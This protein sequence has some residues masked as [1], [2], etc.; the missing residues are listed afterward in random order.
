MQINLRPFLQNSLL[1]LIIGSLLILCITDASARRRYKKSTVRKQAIEMIVTNSEEV[2][3]LAGLEAQISDSLQ[4]EEVCGGDLL[5]GEK[6]EEVE[7]EDDV[8][9]DLEMVK[10]IWLEFMSEDDEQEY[11][12]CGIRK[13]EVMDII[14]DWLGTRYRYGGTTDRGID[15]SAFIRMI[16]NETGDIMLPRTAREQYTIGVPIERENLEF[17]D[18][19]FF[20]TRRYPY[21]SHIGI[22]L[23]DQL[24][25]H[26]SSRYGVT[27]SSLESGYYGRKYIGARR[28]TADDIAKLNMMKEISVEDAT[29]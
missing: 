26:A 24:F 13:V 23:G 8:T 19:I 16:F 17:G 2:S 15:C 3:Q 12:S 10:T 18:M 9:V 29:N 1:V 7:A 27:I 22:Y 20:H 5:E 11:L 28:I 6:P 21:V 14:M 4:L 25:A